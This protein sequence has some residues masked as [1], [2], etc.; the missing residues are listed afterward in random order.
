VVTPQ[1]KMNPTSDDLSP[2]SIPATT[3]IPCTQFVLIDSRNDFC[4]VLPRL[5]LGTEDVASNRQF[6]TDKQ[7]THILNIGAPP[8]LDDAAE[9]LLEYKRIV[10]EDLP[11]SDLLSHFSSCNELIDSVLAYERRAILVHCRAG[12]SR[13]PTIVAAYLMYKF[14]WTVDEA[15]FKI[16]GIR[17]K[18][19]PNE[20]FMAQ[21]DLYREILVRGNGCPSPL[22]S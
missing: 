21:L 11:G 4:E 5:Y 22:Q 17:P 18:I 1:A 6:R 15:L 2:P 9:G 3:P 16:K 8:L 13:S 20:G 19:W 14:H 10:V 7:I 12:I